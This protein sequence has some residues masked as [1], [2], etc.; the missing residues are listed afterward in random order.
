MA[1]EEQDDLIP[2]NFVIRVFQTRALAEGNDDL[3]A[4]KIFN[5]G[6]DGDTPDPMVANGSQFIK[7]VAGAT[8]TAN[9]LNDANAKFGSRL[10]TETITNINDSTSAIISKVESETQ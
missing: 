6:I 8:I 10:A 4:L 2:T 5:N 1:T 7:G 3:N 9:K